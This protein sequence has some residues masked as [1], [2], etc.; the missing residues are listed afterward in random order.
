MKQIQSED[1]IIIIIQL[2]LVQCC[3]NSIEKQCQCCKVQLK[4]SVNVAKFIKFI[5]TM[6]LL[7]GNIVIKLNS[8]Q[9]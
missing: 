2:I 6:K 1:N 4:N 5:S 7:L 3:F 8:V 9:L